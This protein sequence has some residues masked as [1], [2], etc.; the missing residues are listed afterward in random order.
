LLKSTQRYGSFDTQHDYILLK[1]FRPPL[2]QTKPTVA[3]HELS[4]L[5]A[6][7]FDLQFLLNYF[8]ESQAHRKQE[9]PISFD[10]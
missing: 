10:I 6:W 1:K 4:S 9:R 7:I 8:S 2:S 5:S 3:M